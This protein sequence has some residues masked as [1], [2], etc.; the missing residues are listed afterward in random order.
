MTLSDLFIFTD[1]NGV[2]Q[3]SQPGCLCSFFQ[4]HY[5]NSGRERLSEVKGRMKDKRNCSQDS[6]VQVFPATWAVMSTPVGRSKPPPGPHTFCPGLFEFRQKSVFRDWE[7]LFMCS[8]FYRQLL[9]F[10]FIYS[11]V[12]PGNNRERHKCPSPGHRSSTP[13][14]AIH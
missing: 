3:P 12:I 11:W 1:L 4:N 10:V 2:K 8:F 9:C 5:L 7:G 14:D 13:S 6:A